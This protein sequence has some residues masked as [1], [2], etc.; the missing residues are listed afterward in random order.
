MQAARRKN[1][2]RSKIEDMK[3]EFL[4]VQK[5]QFFKESELRMQHIKEEHN[6]KMKKIK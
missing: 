3:G 1:K 5:K 6:L 2:K 4:I